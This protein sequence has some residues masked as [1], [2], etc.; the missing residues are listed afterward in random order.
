MLGYVCSWF[1]TSEKSPPLEE[2]DW[3][4]VDEE[5]LNEEPNEEIATQPPPLKFFRK[6]KNR[7]K[8]HIVRVSFPRRVVVMTK[9]SH[10]T[11]R[12]RVRNDRRGH[13]QRK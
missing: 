1:S 5:D 7:E 10:S 4:L 9:K 2:E 6:T 8:F 13:F 12:S 3:V 11:K